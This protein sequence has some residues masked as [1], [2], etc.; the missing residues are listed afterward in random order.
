[1]AGCSL[2]LYQNTLP[3]IFFSESGRQLLERKHLLS[4]KNELQRIRFSFKQER[5]KEKKKTQNLK[6]WEK[7]C[8]ITSSL[9][10]KLK[11]ARKFQAKGKYFIHNS[12][13]EAYFI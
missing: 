6:F 10:H 12:F 11:N 7:L 13:H 8:L 5:E 3:F 9:C 1:M 4:F 2:S